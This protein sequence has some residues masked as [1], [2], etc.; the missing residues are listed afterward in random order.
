MPPSAASGAVTPH[1]SGGAAA[2]PPPLLLDDDASPKFIK[3]TNIMLQ[4][5]PL[6]V[7]EDE[8]DSLCVAA[9]L[10]DTVCPPHK[11]AL[12]LHPQLP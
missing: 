5:P 4:P 9:L 1:M 2:L 10:R 11:R 7:R 12:T 8:V 6:L 3:G